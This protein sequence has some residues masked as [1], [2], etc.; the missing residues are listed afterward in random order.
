[1]KNF[2]SRQVF[3]LGI[4][5]LLVIF[6]GCKDKV[7]YKLDY[8]ATLKGIV[9]FNNEFGQP[10]V[11][12]SAFIEI[13]GKD[14]IAS[15][16]SDEDGKYE[17]TN[18]PAGTYDLKV[19]KEPYEGWYFKSIKILGGDV[20]LYYHFYLNVKPQIKFSNLKAAFTDNTHLNVSANVSHNYN[21]QNGFYSGYV[22]ILINKNENVS[23]SN[24]TN[25]GTVPINFESGTEISKE[26]NIGYNYKP[27]DTIYIAAYGRGNSYAYYND[28]IENKT[29]YYGYSNPSEIISIIVP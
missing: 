27:G 15:A 21:V 5:S 13:I 2:F 22:Y 10:V 28:L 11:D 1:M 12:D 17:I 3:V 7:V 9:N 20:P 4:T 29:I 8:N 24:F 23:L 19:T 25:S 6:S 16:Y 18:I 26:F 14:V